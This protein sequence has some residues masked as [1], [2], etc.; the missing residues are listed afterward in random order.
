MTSTDSLGRLSVLEGATYFSTGPMAGVFNNLI[1]FDQHA[2][3]N[4]LD[5]IVTIRVTTVILIISWRRILRIN[6]RDLRADQSVQLRGQDTGLS[7]PRRINA[8]A[9]LSVFRPGIFLS[10][11]PLRLRDWRTFQAWPF[12][13]GL[14]DTFQVRPQ[15]YD[16]RSDEVTLDEVERIRF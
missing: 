7:P 1:M 13:Q 5:T 8:G 11:M 9:C 4:R 2:K 3:Q 6:L 14:T 15:L 10:G 16:R 12:N